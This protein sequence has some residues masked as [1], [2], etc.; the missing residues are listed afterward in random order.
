MLNLKSLIHGHFIFRIRLRVQPP[1]GASLF[2]KWILL[3]VPELMIGAREAENTI[4]DGFGY[5]YNLGMNRATKFY[6][7]VSPPLRSFKRY[8]RRLHNM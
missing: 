6:P 8:R 2:F 3:R 7:G 5:G 1:P 4:G